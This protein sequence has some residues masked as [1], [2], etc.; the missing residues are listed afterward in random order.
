MGIIRTHLRAKQTAPVLVAQI[1]FIGHHGVGVLMLEQLTVTLARRRHIVRHVERCHT[2]LDDRPWQWRGSAVTI[3][4]PVGQQQQWRFRLIN[5]V[6]GPYLL[7][8]R[9]AQLKVSHHVR[10]VARQVLIEEHQGGFVGTILKISLILPP[11]QHREQNQY[12]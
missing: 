10:N 5:R 9:L 4:L 2:N 11:S 12:Q 7:M 6:G 1:V 3:V 8:Q